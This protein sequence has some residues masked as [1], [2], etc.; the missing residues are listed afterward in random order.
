VSRACSPRHGR[1]TQTCYCLTLPSVVFILHVDGPHFRSLP[2]RPRRLRGE[3]ENSSDSKSREGRKIAQPLTPTKS[4]EKKKDPN[5]SKKSQGRAVPGHQKEAKS[6]SPPSPTEKK[7]STRHGKKGVDAPP[8]RPGLGS[9]FFF[10]PS[11]FPSLP[12]AKK[13]TRENEKKQNKIEI[14]HFYG[15]RAGPPPPTPRRWNDAEP[16]KETQNPVPLLKN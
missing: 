1:A 3:D 9:P 15:K 14:L 10:H 7:I 6:P 4:R 11:R 5:K 13:M 12:Q 2:S 16:R 8:K